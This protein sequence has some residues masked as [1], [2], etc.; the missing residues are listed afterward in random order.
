[1]NINVFNESLHSVPRGTTNK[2]PI[3]INKSWL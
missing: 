1:M 2:L 3:Y